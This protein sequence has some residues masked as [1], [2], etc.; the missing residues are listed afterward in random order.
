MDFVI[1][2][3]WDYQKAHFK[4]TPEDY[5]RKGLGL[6]VSRFDIEF[7]RAIGMEQDRVRVKSW[8]DEVREVR[9]S[10]AYEILSLDGDTLHAKG[11]YESVVIDMASH[12]PTSIPEW[13]YAF[14]YEPK[15]ISLSRNSQISIDH[16]LNGHRTEEKPHH[17]GDDM[18]AGDSDPF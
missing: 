7:K 1:Q 9:F 12:R 4:M 16:E 2:S 5:L 10:V 11:R 3:R 8:C 6:W 18:K 15:E 17:S 13:M 14:G